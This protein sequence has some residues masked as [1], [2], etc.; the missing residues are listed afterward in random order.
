MS[1]TIR[2]S[3][4]WLPN[5]ATE[6]THTIVLTGPKSGVFLD[7]RFLKGT[8]ELDWAFAGYRYTSARSF[9]LLGQWLGERGG[10]LIEAFDALLRSSE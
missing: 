10:D 8:D 3:I 2:Q 6:P 1:I 5:E 7:V 4:R 9:S